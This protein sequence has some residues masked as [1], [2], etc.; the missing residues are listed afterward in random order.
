MGNSNVLNDINITFLTGKRYAIIGP[1]GSGGTTLLM[2]LA[3]LYDPTKGHITINDTPLKLLDGDMHRKQLALVS[4]ET[5]LFSGNLAENIL[6]G[7]PSK[8][9]NQS[10]TE[11]AAKQAYIHNF[12][13]SLPNGYE[14]ECGSRG[15]GFS[16]GQR[17]RIALARAL[18]QQPS[19]LLLDEPTNALDAEN[20]A[21]ILR[22]LKNTAEKRITITVTH[23]PLTAID[24]DHI[25][26][27]SSGNLVEMG[28]HGELLAKK[29]VYWAMFHVGRR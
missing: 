16:G 19:I 12:A 28:T 4:Q 6:L 15:I 22:A 10:I 26:V 27:I 23:R 13:T 3:H 7:V 1:S 5:L 17:Q 24:A 11:I 21:A 20:E 9:I 18:A 2:L 29:G 25:V 8:R 14:S